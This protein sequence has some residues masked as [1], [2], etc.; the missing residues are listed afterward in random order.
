MDKIKE[1]IGNASSQELHDL[2][3]FG[4]DIVYQDISLSVIYE[5]LINAFTNDER[6]IEHFGYYGQGLLLRVGSMY[7]W[8]MQV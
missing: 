4:Y 2:F 7:Y 3:N 6:I 1:Y 8:L 5:E